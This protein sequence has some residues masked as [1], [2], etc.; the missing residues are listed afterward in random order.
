MKRLILMLSFL[1]PSA[2]AYYSTWDT[3][4][5]L[6]PGHY[7]SSLE[8]QFVTA[9]GSG[10]N[11]V[12][13]FDMPVQDD[14]VARIMIGAGTVDFHMGGFYK[15]VPY[16]D[17]PSQPAIGLIGGVIYGRNEGY[18][19]LTVRLAPLVSKTFQVNFGSLT[20][21]ASL[22]IGIRSQKNGTDVPIE[23]AIGTD[24]KTM[25]FEHLRWRTELGFN[26]NDAYSYVSIGAV[27][28][29]DEENGIIFE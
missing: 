27:L 3:G 29:F 5:V 8:A 9:D 14:S 11:L 19:Y 1:S 24:I 18:N 21:Y 13:R 10:M 22:P 23:L 26:L 4:D 25:H 20:P 2:F 16:P 28:D 12:G 17:T 7:D 15:Y 6:K